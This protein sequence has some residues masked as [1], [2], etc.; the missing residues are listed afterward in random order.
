MQELV[1]QKLAQ[2]QVDQMLL[3]PGQQAVQILPWLQ[4]VQ[5]HL[6]LVVLHQMPGQ[7]SQMLVLVHQK[8]RLM[9]RQTFIDIVDI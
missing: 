9:G 4:V 2:Q 3:W 1:R 6:W 5:I 8:V 7:A